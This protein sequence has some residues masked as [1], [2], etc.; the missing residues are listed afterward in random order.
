VAVGPG[1]GTEAQLATRRKESLI[2]CTGFHRPYIKGMPGV[3]AHRDIQGGDM[4]TRAE[5]FKASQQRSGPKRPKKPVPAAAPSP[6]L[7]KKAT[8]ALDDA[9]ASQPPARKSTRRS[10]NRQKA[11]TP[12]KARQQ[13]EVT[14]PARRHLTRT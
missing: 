7:G 3:F 4:A 6:S 8:Y 9:V 10:K 13:L 2:G 5:R 11:A 14:S 12:L 1:A